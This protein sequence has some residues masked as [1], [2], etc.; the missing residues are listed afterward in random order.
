MVTTRTGEYGQHIEY[1]RLRRGDQGRGRPDHPNSP[2]GPEIRTGVDDE[3]YSTQN[4][5]VTVVS[6]ISYKSYLIFR[7]SVALTISAFEIIWFII[8]TVGFHSV[9]IRGTSALFNS[10]RTLLRLL[11]SR[12]RLS[13]SLIFEA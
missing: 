4:S 10:V 1:D 7:S 3:I 6:N 8:L 13:P 12:F 11:S 5:I 2:R 9:R